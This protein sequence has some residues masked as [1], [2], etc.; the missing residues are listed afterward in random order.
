M[1]P[2]Y[3]LEREEG[4]DVRHILLLA[5]AIVLSLILHVVCMN[6][7][8]DWQ[9]NTTRVPKTD[10]G[11]S[12]EQPP[13]RVTTLEKDPVDPLKIFDRPA[14]P[15]ASGVSGSD[16]P[17]SI[18]TLSL[19]SIGELVRTPD[20]ALTAPPP[21]PRATMRSENARIPAPE[22]P[23]TDDNIWIPR[24]QIMEVIEFRVRDEVA[25]LP[26]RMIPRIERIETAPDYVPSAA[27]LK[28]EKLSEHSPV[29][30]PAMVPA[31]APAENVAPPSAIA[32]TDLTPVELPPSVKP[33]AM[34]E[35]FGLS[36]DD[37]GDSRPL[38]DRLAATLV[39]RRYADD[40]DTVYF[41][42]SVDRRDAAELPI[43]PKDILFAQDCSRSLA[44][45]RL[46]FCRKAMV[47]ALSIVGPND[48]FNVAGFNDSV[49]MLFPDWTAPSRDAFARAEEFIGAMKSEG[50][51]DVYASIDAL[52]KLPRDPRRPMIILLV[53]DGRATVGPTQ[54]TALIGEL[55]KSNDGAV[56]IFTLGT[57]ANAN[58]YLLDMLAYCN[59]G[60][61]KVVATR[62]WD[63]PDAIESLA[64]SLGRPVLSGV[65]YVVP[66]ASQAQ[67]FPRQA[68][69]LYADRPLQF[70]GAI[71]ASEKEVLVQ[72][73]GTST[74]SDCDVLLQ[75]PIAESIP[76]D[77]TDDLRGSWARQRMY[78]LIGAYARTKDAT[79]LNE[80]RMLSARLRIPIPYQD[81]L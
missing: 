1:R 24:Q 79:L 56:S 8:R 4:R 31:P 41:R 38:D 25:E 15:Q 11:A 74:E 59:R 34:S 46:G 16:A 63:I 64:E 19:E 37:V 48:R 52:L 44:L 71:P 22:L 28:G 42:L 13:L 20:R 53:S 73:L 68:S 50:E 69:N 80:M 67:I 5:G 58:S 7:V 54:S 76:A 65:R 77:A 14:T 75:L 62:R 39:T 61:S 29:V 47:E 72:V 33:A 40:P 6:L 36:P 55:S 27:V 35:S 26:R 10:E 78:D 2:A 12:E 18:G 66:A 17:V 9:L 3:E 57:H 45:E 30:T 32:S 81:E 60:E 70:Y 23:P 43:A 21:A 49:T 51:T